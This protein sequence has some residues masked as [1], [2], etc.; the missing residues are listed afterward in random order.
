MTDNELIIKIMDEGFDFQHRM[1]IFKKTHSSSH[2]EWMLEYIAG[3]RKEIND[4]LIFIDKYEL[5]IAKA[6]IKIHENTL[7]IRQV[8]ENAKIVRMEKDI[9]ELKECSICVLPPAKNAKICEKH[10]KLYSILYAM[11]AELDTKH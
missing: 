6:K 5:P 10:E 8:F 9:E 1:E 4:L 2:A 7:H 11:K 3:I